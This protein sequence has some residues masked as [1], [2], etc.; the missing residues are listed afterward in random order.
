MEKKNQS[1]Q[2]KESHGLVDLNVSIQEW[3]SVISVTVCF[4]QCL[5]IV[6]VYGARQ[7]ACYSN[8]TL[9][10]VTYHLA[11]MAQRS[12]FLNKSRPELYIVNC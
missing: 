4:S 5:L 7:K 6:G 1:W 8:Y 12:M 3:A 9:H 2:T 11:G 10:S